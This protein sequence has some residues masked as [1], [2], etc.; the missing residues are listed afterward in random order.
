[1]GCNSANTTT[2]VAEKTTA[3]GPAP[4]PGDL[5]VPTHNVEVVEKPTFL[6]PKALC[7]I[8]RWCWEEP[9]LPTN[10]TKAMGSFGDEVWSVG[11]K[12]MVL[13][14]TG[15]IWK[16]EDIPTEW[17][18]V[19]FHEIFGTSPHDVWINSTQTFRR[20]NGI[21][22]WNGSVWETIPTGTT[23]PLHGL[24]GVMPTHLFAMGDSSEGGLSTSSNYIYHFNGSR[25]S[26]L[27][28]VGPKNV[29]TLQGIVMS[30]RTFNGLPWP[31]LYGTQTL[32]G[33]DF[34]MPFLLS[35]SPIER[36][37]FQGLPLPK[38]I[39]ER[40]SW[41][42]QEAGSYGFVAS[43]FQENTAPLY[44]WVTSNGES[45]TSISFPVTFGT[46]ALYPAFLGAH[47]QALWFEQGGTSLWRYEPNKTPQ[48]P[49]ENW[50][51]L[52]TNLSTTIP[53]EYRWKKA[54]G[55]GQSLWLFNDQ[56]YSV[57]S[58][59]VLEWDG[60]IWT[61]YG[62]SRAQEIPYRL[63]TSVSGNQF[64]ITARGI[65]HVEAGVPTLEQKGSDWKTI[66]GAWEQPYALSSTAV[67]KRN[68]SGTWEPMFLPKELR[69]PTALWVT[70]PSEIWVA[71][72][73]TQLFFWNGMRWNAFP[74]I[75]VRYPSSLIQQ[76]L[77]FSP[78]DVW[79]VTDLGELF[80]M[81]GSNWSK[82]YS[83]WIE[84]IQG[85]SSSNLWGVSFGTLVHFD[86]SNWISYPFPSSVREYKTNDLWIDARKQLWVALQPGTEILSFDGKGWKEENIPAIRCTAPNPSHPLLETEKLQLSG[87]DKNLWLTC[88]TAFLH[89]VQSY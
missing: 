14:R 12:G 27:D 60:T 59:E 81:E 16:Q 23:L 85:T 69:Q 67:W 89:K 84:V 63:W 50:S 46:S 58:G 6:P 5:P 21:L 30:N 38:P 13:H 48:H 29:V 7:S 1:M 11:G 47:Q 54:A 36:N 44:Q 32:G 73:Q 62:A 8:D 74:T 51:L 72:E 80:H 55:Q 64:G 41:I 88:G 20:P 43:A 33:K 3:D 18:Q 42:L 26:L 39:M 78:N 61:H 83:S 28:E 71:G 82:P 22:H 75:P 25:W 35:Y 86:G 87:F 15:G 68:S 65:V 31:L 49:T 52:R 77:A 66:H 9:F 76:I 40:P 19:Y 34:S 17:Q 70:T 4:P 53:T 24:T 10:Q 2:L 56:Y 79:V 57:R 37:P 45:K